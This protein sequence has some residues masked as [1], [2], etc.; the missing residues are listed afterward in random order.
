MIERYVYIRLHKEY[1]EERIA[2]AAH[3]RAVLARLPGVVQFAVGTPADTHS[4]NAWDLSIAVR[5]SELTDIEAFRTHPDHRQLID[6]YLQPRMHVIKAWN[7][8][9]GSPSSAAESQA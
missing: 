9:L 1:A 6:E 4:E 3:T 2:I 5:F 7:F 8:Q